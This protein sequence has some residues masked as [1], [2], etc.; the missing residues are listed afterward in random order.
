MSTL[1][2]V[3]TARAVAALLAHQQKRLGPVRSLVQAMQGSSR[4]FAGR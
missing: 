4:S 1:A 3:A 2:V